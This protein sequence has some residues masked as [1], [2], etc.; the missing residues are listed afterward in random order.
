MSTLP[1][2]KQRFRGCLLAMACGD[3]LGAGIEF[4]APE[5]IQDRYGIVRDLIGG[6][7]FNWPP[8]AYTDDTQ[9]ALALAESLIAHPEIDY[10]DLARRWIAW[11]RSEPPDVGNLTRNALVRAETYLEQDRD[12]LEAGET[13]WHIGG[14]D[15]AG[16]G[17]LMRTAPVALLLHE[18]TARM[19]EVAAK[20]CALTHYDPRCRA[21]CIVLCLA[22]AQMLRS[23]PGERLRLDVYA[24]AVEEISIKTATAVRAVETMDFDEVPS[25]GYTNDTLQAAL[26]PATHRMELEEGLI[27]TVNLGFDADT[28]GAVAGAVLGARDG[29]NAIPQ[30]WL[31]TLQEVDVIRETADRL[32]ELAT[33]A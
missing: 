19:Q 16:N 12:V 1:T 26:W 2:L 33:N 21:S 14:E 23:G 5:T 29:E 10:T 22:I 11:L 4:M 25:S 24:E 20:I 7:P 8:G 3:A 13:T 17:G 9:M 15:D 30:R 28:C 18:Q 6:G 31:D 32:Y 27:A